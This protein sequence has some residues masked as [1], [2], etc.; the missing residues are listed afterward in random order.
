MKVCIV[1]IVTIRDNVP[2]E[3][4][5][6]MI[7]I[8]V[9]V[10]YIYIRMLTQV[11]GKF[12][13]SLIFASHVYTDQWAPRVP[14]WHNCPHHVVIRMFDGRTIVF[15]QQRQHIKCLRALLDDSKSST[16]FS[17]LLH[18]AGRYEIQAECFTVA[19]ALC[20]QPIRY[21]P[22]AQCSS[23]IMYTCVH[24]RFELLHIGG[25]SMATTSSAVCIVRA[26]R[27]T[28]EVGPRAGTVA[29]PPI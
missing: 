18:E 5:A 9:A 11:S 2:Q 21:F 3:S 14:A 13:S 23:V 10:S 8:P 25:S 6:L 20:Q 27:V 28:Y 12:Q 26:S 1:N 22:A 19:D 7:R 24:Q 29:R 4:K 15:P 17:R 16:R